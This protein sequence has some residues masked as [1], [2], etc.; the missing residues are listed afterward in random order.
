MAWT[1]R[2]PLKTDRPVAGGAGLVRLAVLALLWGSSFLWIKLGLR[3]FSP[4]QLTFARLLLGALVLIPIVV[5]QGQRIPRQ[6]SVWGHIFVAA[7]VANAIPYLL[8]AVAEQQ[9]GSNIAGV[10][11]S[12]TPLWTLLLGFL[13]GIDRHVTAPKAAGFGLGFLGVVVMF[14]PWDS[15]GEVASWGGLA[16]LAAALSYAISYLYMGRYL[17]NRGISPLMLSASQ[18]TAATLILTC[19]MTA[20]GREHVAWRAD[21]LIGVLVLGILG[22]GA[23]YVLNYRIIQD[24]GP[25]IASTVTYLLPIVAVILGWAVLQETVTIAVILGVA[26]VLVGIALTRRKPA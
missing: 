24:D 22:T 6:R 26:L 17:T 12:T 16:C 19:V 7:L 25:A 18:L 13:V 2:C 3:G 9:I 21:A 10:I 1:T 8:F 20:T 4:T 14:G 11:N 23:A 15:A 5:F